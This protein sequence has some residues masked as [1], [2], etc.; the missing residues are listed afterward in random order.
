M[1]FRPGRK[2]SEG[3]LAV[4]ALEVSVMVV[5]AK[6]LDGLLKEIGITGKEW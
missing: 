1:H 2:K 6:T 3:M 4:R 5:E